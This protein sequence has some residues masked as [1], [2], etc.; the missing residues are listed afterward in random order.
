[1]KI[2]RMV[3]WCALG[4][5]FKAGTFSLA[6]ILLAK[7]ASKIFFMS[8]LVAN[9]YTLLLNLLFYKYFGLTGMGYS[10]LLS[11]FLSFFQ[12][13]IINRY[14]YHFKF[15]DTFIKIFVLQIFL[16]FACLLVT[17]LVKTDIAPILCLG[18][19]ILSA[20]YSTVILLNVTQGFRKE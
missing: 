5:Y 7:G 12:L 8:E 11:Y 2:E 9:V 3:R 19:I 13:I 15:S 4:I 18:L 17:E 16:G 14:F 6:Y 10:F 1:M 20:L